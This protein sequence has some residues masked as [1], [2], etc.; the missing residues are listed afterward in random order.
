MEFR[1][2]FREATQS[3]SPNDEAS[4]PRNPAGLHLSRGTAVGP[5]LAN[6]LSQ[7]L[8]YLGMWE[9]TGVICL[10]MVSISLF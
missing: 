10:L 2:G 1:P 7:E 5:R 8:H 9:E 6:S 4:F 3:P